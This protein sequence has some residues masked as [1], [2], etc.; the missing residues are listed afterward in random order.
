MSPQECISAL[1]NALLSGGV[2]IIL[3]RL[4]SGAVDAE[5]KCRA[6]VRPVNQVEIA[7]G[8]KYTSQVAIV[9]P[10]DIKAAGWPNQPIT[11]LP[12]YQPQPWLPKINDKAIILGRSHNVSFAR[13]IPH[14]GEVVRIELVVDA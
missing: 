8:I 3:Q 5:A 7:A 4:V 9:S 12:P 13:A 1:D 6:L 2:D 11:D 14:G 10:T